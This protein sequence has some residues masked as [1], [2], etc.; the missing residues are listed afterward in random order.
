MLQAFEL[1]TYVRKN[2]EVCNFSASF[3][4]IH[5]PVANIFH[6]IGTFTITSKSGIR[7]PDLHVNIHSN[8]HTESFNFA[9]IMLSSSWT[10]TKRIYW[11]F[12][13]I[14]VSSLKFLLL[15]TLYNV[16]YKYVN[17][18]N[19][20]QLFKE[21]GNHAYRTSN[22]QVIQTFLTHE[23]VCLRGRSIWKHVSS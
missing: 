5:L 7:L 22:G 14:R 12:L 18:M 10:F 8:K 13:D 20:H 1:A 21:L 3:F 9:S 2:C 19:M 17:C 4:S 11:S 6:A 15:Q 23:M 16:D